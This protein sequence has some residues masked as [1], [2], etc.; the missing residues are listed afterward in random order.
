[1]KLTPLII[2]VLFLI[3]I[4]CFSKKENKQ[5]NTVQNEN[6]KKDFLIKED[7]TFLKIIKEL[8]EIQFFLS[9]RDSIF[10]TNNPMDLTELNT[11]KQ[12]FYSPFDSV[13]IGL[14]KYK[15]ID[16]IRKFHVRRKGDKK[17]NVPSA[18]IIQLNF[19]NFQNA[20]NWFDSYDKSIYRRIIENKPKTTLWL[21]ENKIYFIQT[22]RTPNRDPLNIIKST[23]IKKLEN[24]KDI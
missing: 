23:I 10:I 15:N 12:V 3:L 16:L 1:M 13:E 21:D 20:Q 6:Y 19:K 5:N 24:Y 22:Y 8:E 7:S 2:L 4:S 17:E 11:L 14:K 18:N 9:G